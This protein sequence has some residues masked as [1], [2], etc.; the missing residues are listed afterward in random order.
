MS[1]IQLLLN[2]IAAIRRQVDEVQGLA[3]DVG[4]A[5]DGAN[6]EDERVRRLDRNVDVGTRETVLL[7]TT[8]RQLLPAQ[9]SGEVV[10]LPRQLTLRSRRVLEQARALLEQLRALANAL[11]PAGGADPLAGRYHETVAMAEVALRMI[12]AFPDAPSAQLRLCEG[13][14][15]ILGVVGSRVAGLETAVAERRQE[16]ERIDR[17]VGLL[18]TLAQTGRIDLGD[19]TRLAE[20]VLAEA[21][22]GTSLRF[23]SADPSD[24]GRFIACRGL[25]TAQVVARLIRGDADFRAAPLRPV[26]AALVYD[27]GMLSVPAAVLGQSTPL[28][29]GQRR[30]IEAHGNGGADLLTRALPASAW[31]A[32]AAA[33]HHERLDGT[34]YPGGLTTPQLS[35]LVRL[36][37]VCDVYTALCCPRAHR[38]ALD[39]RTALTDTLL[40][41]EQGAL[42]KHYAERLLQLSFYPVGTVVELADGAVGLVVATHMGRRD[43]TTPARPVVA[44]LVDAERRPLAGPRHIDL[45]EC[46]SRSIVRTLPQAQR[47]ELLRR[48][49]PELA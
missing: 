22:D 24:V 42:D 17:L 33:G 19:L 25:T 23:L 49:F 11:E 34:G 26:L 18:Q 13:L 46:E 12:Q 15:G 16:G 21:Q 38:A 47:R 29:D 31:L 39:T 10:V 7:D 32:E 8:L 48:H 6:G 14:E 43:L 4:T 37:A 35:P 36:L 44:L 45:A 40:L 27:V 3:K 30:L 1:D 28:D 5:V 41:A 9:V 20:G 2:K